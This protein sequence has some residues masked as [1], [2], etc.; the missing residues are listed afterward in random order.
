MKFI[1]EKTT[2]E[3]VLK[4]IILF[5]RGT[6]SSNTMQKT[7]SNPSFNANTMQFKQEP[8][9][10]VDRQTRGRPSRRGNFSQKRGSGVTKNKNNQCRNCGAPNWSREHDCPAKGKECKLCKRIG[11]FASMCKNAQPKVG[12]IEQQ[13]DQQSQDSGVESNRSQSKCSSQSN[14]YSALHHFRGIS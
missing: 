12:N 3:E 5:E 13:D 11:H 7:V 14:F 2:P 6:L 10:A 8:T 1:R 9:F 4:Y